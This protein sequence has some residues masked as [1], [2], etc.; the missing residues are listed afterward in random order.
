MTFCLQRKLSLQLYKC[1]LSTIKKDKN[2]FFNTLESSL[3]S[4]QRDEINF[5]RFRASP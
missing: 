2:F 5:K 4:G 3:T 1:S